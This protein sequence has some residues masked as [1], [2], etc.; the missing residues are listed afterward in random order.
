MLL[1]QA[2]ALVD[3]Q[4][5]HGI[6]ALHIASAV[7]HL[8]C[9]IMLVEHVADVNKCRSR[10]DTHLMACAK[11]DSFLVM[12]YLLAHGANVNAV[13]EN[14][15]TALQNAHLY[16]H[17][18]CVELLLE[19][20]ADESSFQGLEFGSERGVCSLYILKQF[21]IRNCL[22]LLFIIIIIRTIMMKF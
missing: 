6:T 9:V 16:G 19:H 22:S 3:T 21:N 14:G 1:L 12:S 2:G 7:G 13:N 4:T 20:G 18:K 15:F 17:S 8:K 10:G 5:I 11:Y